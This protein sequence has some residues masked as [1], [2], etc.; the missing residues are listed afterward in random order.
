MLWISERKKQRT[1]EKSW[2]GRADKYPLGVMCIKLYALK[3]RQIVSRVQ[4][5][6]SLL[7]NALGRWLV[8]FIAFFL[9]QIIPV[10]WL[11]DGNSTWKCTISTPNQAKGAG[12]G[13]E[14]G[15]RECKNGA[16]SKHWGLASG[17]FGSPPGG[18]YH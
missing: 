1:G 3:E 6:G 15:R 18:K 12:V 2:V 10:N 17:I 9:T 5:Q 14:E 4:S 16:L 8:V 7:R 11:I 13:P